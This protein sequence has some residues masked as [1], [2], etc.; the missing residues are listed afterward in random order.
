[1]RPQ[2]KATYGILKINSGIIF[3][4]LPYSS[5]STCRATPSGSDSR[6]WIL[7]VPPKCVTWHGVTHGHRLGKNIMLLACASLTSWACTESPSRVSTK[8]RHSVTATITPSTKTQPPQPSR[9][10]PR[11]PPMAGSIYTQMNYV[12]NEYP[13]HYMVYTEHAMHLSF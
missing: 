6:L 12:S 11:H 7:R 2:T 5:V 9:R 4:K 1:M 8:T 13:F 10:P 3:P